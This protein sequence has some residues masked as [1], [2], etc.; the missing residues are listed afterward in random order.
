MAVYIKLEKED[1]L[2]TRKLIL[3]SMAKIAESRNS[4]F[5]LKKIKQEKTRTNAG[6]LSKLKEINDAMNNINNLMPEERLV[7]D[8]SETEDGKTRTRYEDEIEEIRK[9]IESLGG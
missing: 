2:K 5:S 9:R 1:V 3:E 4:L 7:R 8:I 6:I